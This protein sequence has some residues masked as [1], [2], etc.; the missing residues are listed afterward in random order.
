MKKIA[1]IELD[2]HAE[3]AGNFLELMK[4]S[5]K[6]SVDYYFSEKILNL[7]GKKENQNIY[8]VSKNNLLE[9]LKNK[10]YDLVIIGTVHRYFNVFL[11]IS[12]FFPI[13]IIGHNL[14]FIQASEWD[15]LKSIFRKGRIFRLKLLLKEGL[16]YKRKIYEKAY[17]IFVLDKNLASGDFVYLPLFFNEHW[18]YLEK[19]Y[20]KIVIPGTV[21][22]GL[23]DY[24]KVIEELK[25]LKCEQNIEVVFL[26]K[27]ED[28][29]LEA[30]IKLEAILKYNSRIRLVYFT[31]KVSQ[32]VFDEE[33]KNADI[34]Y[35]PIQMDT[36]FFSIKERY[37]RTK[38]SGNIGDAIKFGK[39]IYLPKTYQS[40]Y[41]F[42]EN[43]NLSFAEILMKNHKT[44][45]E[46]WQKLEKELVLSEIEKILL[47]S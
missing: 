24:F 28:K 16:L 31:E 17:K 12:K 42:V 1:Y 13:A 6:I 4:N 47:S 14:N 34:L 9:L 22:Q 38:I 21:S 46:N 37:G 18:G 33:M 23:R 11:K 30:I 15:L 45:V 29:E 32:N 43:K 44:E 2:T 25:E 27:A 36:E 7:L 10:S 26:G 3:I 40:N 19:D 39:K 35:C 8:Q 5:Q 20:L 41:F